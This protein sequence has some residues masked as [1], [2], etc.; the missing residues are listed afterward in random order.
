M[1]KNDIYKDGRHP[2]VERAIGRNAFVPNDTRL[3]NDN[4]L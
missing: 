1:T 2:V 4:R 3:D